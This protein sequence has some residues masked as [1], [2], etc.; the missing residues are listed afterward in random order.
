MKHTPLLG[1][2]RYRDP[3]NAA[4]SAV[5]VLSIMSDIA[6]PLYDDSLDIADSCV[7]SSLSRTNEL[8][9]HSQAGQAHGSTTMTQREESSEEDKPSTSISEVKHK[10]K[11]NSSCDACVSPVLERPETTVVAV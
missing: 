8:Q 11:Q 4:H 7:L 2:E 5:H 6:V 9:Q 1:T 10:R 3:I